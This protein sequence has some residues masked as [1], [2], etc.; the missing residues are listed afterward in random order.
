[1]LRGLYAAA[2]ALDAAQIAHEATAD[3]LANATTPGHRQTGVRFET[4]DL[5]LGRGIGEGGDIVGTRVASTYRD[6]KVGNM[7]TT[8]NPYDLALS[9]PDQF[10]VVQGPNGPLYTRDGAFRI[11]PQGQVLTQAGYSLLA[12]AGAVE[13]PANTAVTGFAT[14]GSVTADGNPVGR[15]RVVRFAD[16]GRL[17]AVGPVHFEAPPDVTPQPAAP[18]LL[19]GVREG[20]NVNAAGA[21][22]GMIAANRYYE[23]AQRVLRAIGE[24]VQLNTKPQG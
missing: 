22:V 8:G 13:V 5:S 15:V 12:E 19:Q 1:M 16:L 4:L 24:S 14:D 11:T 10:F 23:A 20:S 17:K 9:E 6:F 7:Q 2:S 18:R 21:M 3:N